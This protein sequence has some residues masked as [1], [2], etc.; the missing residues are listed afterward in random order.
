MKSK[1]IPGKARAF[2]D[3]FGR[4]L[5][6]CLFVFVWFW[7]L[8]FSWFS[9]VFVIVVLVGFGG[10]FFTLEMPE[11]PRQLSSQKKIVL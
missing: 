9:F 11:W 10:F 8:V 6:F 1:K 2:S 3:F 5:W 4:I 7:G